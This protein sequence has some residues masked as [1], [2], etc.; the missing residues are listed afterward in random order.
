MLETL[1]NKLLGPLERLFRSAAR[2][3]LYGRTTSS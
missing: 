1:L 3:R 2:S